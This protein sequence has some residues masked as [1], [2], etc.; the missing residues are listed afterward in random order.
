MK[1]TP[2][3]SKS[4]AIIAAVIVAIYVVVSLIIVIPQ[5]PLRSAVSSAL[6]PYFSQSW[7]VFA[8]NIMKVNSDL[9]FQAAWYNEDG[10]LEKSGWVNI[11]D[12][13]QAT[14]TGNLTPSRSQK[15]TWNAVS[16]YVGRYNDLNDEQRDRVRDTFIQ[17]EGDG[18]DRIPDEEIVG[19]L[20]S[21]GENSSDV[22]RFMRY[23]YMLMRY[24]TQFATAYYGEDIERVRWKVERTRANDFEHRFDEK[25]QFDI[26]D[27]VFGWRQSIANTDPEIIDEFR[28]LIERYGHRS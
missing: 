3:Q 24:V 8:P 5:N 1:A 21:Y 14:V 15:Q 13:E 16:T 19:E 23:D 9:S 6:S 18:Y 22:V 17:V 28:D 27:I 26:P 2:R 11:T 25:A 4:M 7:R 12:I 10:E 20:E